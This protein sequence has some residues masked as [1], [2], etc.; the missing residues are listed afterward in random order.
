MTFI[1]SSKQKSKFGIGENYSKFDTNGTLR[2]SGD[3]T[4]YKDKLQSL[5]TQIKNIPSDQLIVNYAEG[6]L[7]FKDTSTLSDYALMNVQINHDWQ[8]GSDVHPHI[9]WFQNQVS[10][11]NWLVQYRWQAN[12]QPKTTAWSNFVLDHSTFSYTSGTILQIEGST[13]RITPPINA[14]LSDI[15]QLRLIRDT[16]NTSGLFSGVDTYTGLARTLNFD[17][18][19]KI[20][21]IGSNEEFTK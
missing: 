21:S 4:V 18:H 5:L 16:Q 6:T 2:M 10:I 8:I 14:G 1:D 7:D 9:H 20:N 19:Y 17:V 15:L 12:G 3:A 11:P 13:S